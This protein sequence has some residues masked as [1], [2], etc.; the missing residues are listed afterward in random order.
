MTHVSPY[1]TEEE[2]VNRQT[3]FDRN[4]N[5]NTFMFETPFTQG[6][7]AHGKLEEQWKR[8]V[9]I[10]TDYTFPYVKKRIRVIDTEVRLFCC[11]VMG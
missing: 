5:I 7:K 9:I 6:G 1:F 11:I 2:R 8:R 10:K 4:S 3:E